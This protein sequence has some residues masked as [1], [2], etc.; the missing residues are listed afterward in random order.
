MRLG[1][2]TYSIPVEY[3]NTVVI[4]AYTKPSNNYLYIVVD[5]G[6]E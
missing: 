3:Y 6:F 4:G 2:L 1:E 5:G